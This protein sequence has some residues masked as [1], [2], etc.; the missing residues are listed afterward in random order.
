MM[1][2][3]FLPIAFA[4]LSPFTPVNA[5]APAPAETPKTAKPFSPKDTLRFTRITSAMHFFMKMGDVAK[6]K[7][8]AG[9][10]AVNAFGGAVREEMLELWTPLVKLAEERNVDA[11]SIPS[12][13]SERELEAIEQLKKGKPEKWSE[14]Y[15]ELFARGGRRYS[16]TLASVVAGIENP[17]FKKMGESVLKLIASQT[18]KAAAARAEE[19][20]R[21]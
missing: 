20:K 9:N 14:E 7:K 5:Q 16:S 12:A 3:F 21:K 2:K 11:R 17:D 1:K 13:P 18:E 10:P 6:R 15:Y 8:K 19:K 4:I